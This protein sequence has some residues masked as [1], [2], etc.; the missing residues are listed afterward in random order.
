[1][2]STDELKV[3]PFRWFILAMFCCLEISNALLWVTFA[4]ISDIAGNYFGG[5]YYGSTTSVNM[6][7]NIYLILYGPG[8]IMSI[9]LMK[10]C[11]PKQSMIIAGSLNLLGAFIRYIASANSSSIGFGTLYILIMIGQSFAAISQPFFVNCPPMIA[12]TWFPVNERE[13]ATT[14]GSVCSPVG[15]AI[16]QLIPVYLVAQQSKNRKDCH[17]FVTEK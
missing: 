4:P 2:Q 6:L 13:M 14:I 12:A 3:Y 10:Y 8:T 7:A 9:I 1:M 5:G 15:N 16:G 17:A 11:K